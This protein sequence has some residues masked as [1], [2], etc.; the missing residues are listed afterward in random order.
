[1]MYLLTRPAELPAAW[2]KRSELISRADILSYW[3]LKD[4]SPGLTGLLFAPVM[5]LAATGSGRGRSSS[6]WLTGKS[7]RAS[8]HNPQL[9]SGSINDQ[10]VLVLCQMLLISSRER[11]VGHR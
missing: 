5:A 6:P 4:S 2:S 8:R 1:M 3:Q 9:S 7:A 10:I 11:T